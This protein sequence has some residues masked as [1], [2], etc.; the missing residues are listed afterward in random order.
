MSIRKPL[1]RVAAVSAVVVA[2]LA[3]GGANGVGPLARVT[4][5]DQV[6][7]PREMLA[8]SL[9]TVI[10]A[11]SVH[12]AVSVAGHA[13]GALLGRPDASVTLDGT[14]IA[15]DVRPQDA[16]SH[17][18]VTSAPLAIDLEAITMW[19]TLAY[20]SGGAGPW[21][22]GSLGA[23]VG[24]SG[25]DANPLTLVDRLRAWRAAPGAPVPT[26]TD[27]PCAAPSGRCHEVRLE[28]GSAP[29]E[30]VASLF[31]A[32]GANA[33]GA[34]TTEVVLQVDAMTLRPV[35]LGLAIANADGSLA[36][37]ITGDASGWDD[38]SV[39][40]DPAAG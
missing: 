24:E 40:P 28:A 16:R 13:P 32:G 39:I 35:H 14:K 22:R 25:I 34:T 21:T 26:A 4:P 10:D 19:D 5:P 17:I 38:P 7:D 1:V 27:V 30:V 33:V 8:R 3:V 29:G 11:S 37:Q 2:L 36:I 6:T 23:V 31:P 18:A 20:R 12:I 9:Q 15:I